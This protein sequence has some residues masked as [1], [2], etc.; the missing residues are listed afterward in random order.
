MTSEATSD[1]SAATVCWC[2]GEERSESELAR[3]ECHSE[4]ALCDVC[5][6][7]LGDKQALRRGNRLRRAIPILA[8]ADIARALEHYAALGFETEAWGGG[9]YGFA[10]RDGVELHLAEIEDH[11]PATN[12][13]SCYLFVGD[14]D[15][16]HAEWV[17]ARAGGQLEAPS[18]TDY[19]LREGRHVDPDGNIVRYGSPLPGSDQTPEGSMLLAADDALAVAATSAVQAGDLDTLIRLLDD[20]PDLAA[21]RIGDDTTSRTLVHA[22]TDWPGHF[23]GV[24]QV[25]AALV[26]AGADVNAGFVGSH[27]ETPLHWSASSDDVDALDALIDA[28]ADLE[29]PGAVLGGGSPLADAVGFGQWNAARR[30]VERGATTRLKDAAALGLMDRVEAFFAMDPPPTPEA[31]TDALWA[32]CHAGQRPTAE[33]LLERGADINAIGWDDLTPL[34]VAIQA[35]ATDLAAWL[36]T[37]GAKSADELR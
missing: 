4:V 35:D 6:D 27:A 23:P 30:L 9:G 33:H 19:G 16:L 14:A 28:G 37:K 24:R 21:A 26:G 29:A 3:L 18:D 22:A 32:A 11:D 12:I 34:E 5:L 2:C 1:A 20:N 15:A 10:S 25:I 7:W 13:V 17:D 36:R 8:T 31:V